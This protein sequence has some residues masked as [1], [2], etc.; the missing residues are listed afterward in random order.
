MAQ[1]DA[2]RLELSGSDAAVPRVLAFVVVKR[3]NPRMREAYG[4]W[5]VEL[6][7]EESYGWW[8]LRRLTLP[9]LLFG[10]PGSLNGV[11]RA[12]HQ[13]THVRDPYHGD[14]ADHRFHPRL[15][16][17]KS[18]EQVRSE[19]R[20]FAQSYR[21]RWR[22]EWWWSRADARHCRTF[23]Q[24]LFAAVGIEEGGDLLHTRGQ[25]CPFLYP[26]RG[27]GWRLLDA[28]AVVRRKTTMRRG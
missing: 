2:W 13:G 8:P 26:I 20:A 10:T 11:G 16:V 4:H 1:P 25:G 21:G 9:R 7:G 3:N 15:V 27:V 23:Q 24:D 14:V 5:W 28:A 18:D 22:W 12:H 19:V 6:D 17:A